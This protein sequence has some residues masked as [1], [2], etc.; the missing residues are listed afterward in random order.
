MFTMLPQEIMDQIAYYLPY[1]KGIEISPYLYKK[2]NH[3]FG[4]DDWLIGNNLW[5]MVANNG[6]LF[7]LEWMHFQTVEGCTFFAMNCAASKGHLEIVKWLHF[8][9]SEV[10][11]RNAMNWAVSNGHLEIVKWLHINTSQ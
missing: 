5:N 6:N 4:S 9:R 8:N 2:L 10:S 11:T 1:L 3:N 7:R